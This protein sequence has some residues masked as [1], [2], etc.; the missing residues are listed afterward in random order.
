MLWVIFQSNI[1]MTCSIDERPLGNKGGDWKAEGQG[2]GV[3]KE[4]HRQIHW[5]HVV[6]VL[7]NLQLLF[8]CFQP[9]CDPEVTLHISSQASETALMRCGVALP[10]L[11]TLYYVFLLNVYK[12][13]ETCELVTLARHSLCISILH[14]QLQM[15]QRSTFPAFY[16]R[17]ALGKNHEIHSS[18]VSK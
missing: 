18:A 13:A 5:L 9:S 2:D 11:I 15:Y 14:S 16:F 10:G 6:Y 3:C 8:L 7:H 12:Y 1:V 4:V 17:S